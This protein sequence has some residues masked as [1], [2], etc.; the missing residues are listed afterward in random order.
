[1]DIKVRFAGNKRVDAIWG[2]RVVHTDQSPLHGGEGSAPEP[3]ELFLAS[4]ATCAGVYVLGFCQA[5]NIPTD[6]IELAQRSESDE[7]GR[8]AKVTMEISVPAAVAREALR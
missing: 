6:G 5:R 4:L 2:D 7:A 1:M 8:L 3:F